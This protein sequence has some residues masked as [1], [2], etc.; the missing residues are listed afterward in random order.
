MKV[1]IGEVNIA[2]TLSTHKGEYCHLE[3]QTEGYEFACGGEIHVIPDETPYNPLTDMD[4][5]TDAMI[6]KAVKV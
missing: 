2:E 4:C 3:F 6:N 5:G 1:L